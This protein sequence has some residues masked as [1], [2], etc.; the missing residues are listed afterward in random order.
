M[1]GDAALRMFHAQASS[2]G[3]RHGFLKIA[4]DF[5]AGRRGGGGRGHDGEGC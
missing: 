2:G 5:L 1:N 4:G 3:E